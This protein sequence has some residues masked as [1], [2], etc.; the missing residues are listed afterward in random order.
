M[1]HS[2]AALSDARAADIASGY[3]Y[4]LRWP[5]TFDAPYPRRMIAGGF[6]DFLG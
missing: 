4:W 6:L 2:A 1:R 3:R 5:V